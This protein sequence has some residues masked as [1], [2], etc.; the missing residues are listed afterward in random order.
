MA[1]VNELSPDLT[2]CI[3]GP[4]G[5]GKTT[6][7]SL[8]YKETAIEKIPGDTTRPIRFGE[9]AGLDFNYIDQVA[10]DYNWHNQRY[11][12]PVYEHTQ[13]NSFSYGS[14]NEWLSYGNKLIAP[15]ST[16]TTKYIQGLLHS[17]GRVI[18]WVHLYANDQERILR[19]AK[20]G[21]SQNEQQYR[22]NMGDSM[23]VK[24]EA[25]LNINSSLYTPHEIVDEILEEV[26]NLPTVGA[27]RSVNHD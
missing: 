9:R 6:I 22:L 23:G 3:T 7:S 16:E 1:G 12:D 26:A 2:I 20:R 21:I 19:L 27:L 14:P 8:L 15:T 11:I 13:F 4:S 5:S 10:F 24:P 25:T 17:M 18:L